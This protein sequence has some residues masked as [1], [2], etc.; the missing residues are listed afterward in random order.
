M[1]SK[2]GVAHDELTRFIAQAGA[3][4]GARRDVIDQV[5]GPIAECLDT[6]VDAAL[7]TDG[8]LLTLGFNELA[9]DARISWR[10]SPLDLSAERPTKQ[11]LLMDDS[12]SA[13]LAG[14][15]VSRLASRVRS[16]IVNGVAELHLVFDH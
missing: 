15:L 9:I 16:R 12:A 1:V 5:Q 4:W 2:D 14:Y 6:L 10:G 8:A 7:S 13:R 3:S 11:E